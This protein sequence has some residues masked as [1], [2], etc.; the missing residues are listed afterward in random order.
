MNDWLAVAMEE[1]KS[2]RAEILDSSKNQHTVIS[3][4]V[5]IFAGLLTLVGKLIGDGSY[6]TAGF[7]L[8]LLI[9]WTA[10]VV[11]IIWSVEFA[12]IFRI[13]Y[14]LCIRE[15]TINAHILDDKRALYWETWLAESRRS[16]PSQTPEI[17]RIFALWIYRLFYTAS[18]VSGCFLMR[19]QAVVLGN[20]VL[21]RK[22]H[23]GHFGYVAVAQ[24]IV[25]CLISSLAVRLVRSFVPK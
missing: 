2:L 13:G 8:I 20:Y 3:Y 11:L 24:M 21:I 14:Y 4:A 12:K 22:F 1:Y 9:P 23:F 19:G 15:R 10:S 25:L 17:Y 5:V 18:V 7:V 6:S 16:T